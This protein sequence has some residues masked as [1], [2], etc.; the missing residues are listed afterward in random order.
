[1]PVYDGTSFLLLQNT[2]LASPVSVIYY[3]EYEKISE[4][5]EKIQT[6][7]NEIQCVV[8]NDYAIENNIGF[9]KTQHPSLFDYPDK[10]DI[11]LFCIS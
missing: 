3:E 8:S 4:I 5:S 1:M 9:G 2:A 6:L 7:K 11:L 10:E